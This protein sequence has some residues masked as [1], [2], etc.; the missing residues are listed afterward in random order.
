MKFWNWIIL[1]VVVMT[2]YK[3][4]IEPRR[5]QYTP[6][7]KRILSDSWTRTRLG[8]CQRTSINVHRRTLVTVSVGLKFLLQVLY[9]IVYSLICPVK[10]RV[11]TVF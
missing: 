6:F 1:F 2:V 8:E 4:F 7:K 10:Q 11:F 3:M 9:F 5:S